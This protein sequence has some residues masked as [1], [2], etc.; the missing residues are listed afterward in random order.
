MNIEVCNLCKTVCNYSLYTVCKYQ[1]CKMCRA[2]PLGVRALSTW[3][4]HPDI[5]LHAVKTKLSIGYYATQ[6]HAKDDTNTN[7]G[8]PYPSK[9]SYDWEEFGS[10]E[11]VKF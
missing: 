3:F 8:A 1:V 11:G 9:K 10:L 2:R 4:T 6:L 7:H 5:F